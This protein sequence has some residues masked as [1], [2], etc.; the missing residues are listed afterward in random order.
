VGDL[1]SDERWPE[2]SFGSIVS[3]LDAFPSPVALNRQSITH[4]QF[5]VCDAIC[6]GIRDVL[7]PGAENPQDSPAT[8]SPVI[9]NRSD[10]VKPPRSQ[11]GT[12]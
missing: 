6:C 8:I 11:L 10:F 1:A 7:S 2:N 4:S 5:D 9:T 3:R 12:Y